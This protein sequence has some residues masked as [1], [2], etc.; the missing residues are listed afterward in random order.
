MKI[1]CADVFP[2]WALLLAA[3]FVSVWNIFW[4]AMFLPF[5]GFLAVVF[6]EASLA[7]VKRIILTVYTQLCVG[8]RLLVLHVATL[9]SLFVPILAI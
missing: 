6:F 4:G 5:L 3:F 1:I 7:Y 9:L 2:V 8:T